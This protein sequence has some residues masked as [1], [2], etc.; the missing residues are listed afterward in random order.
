MLRGVSVL[1]AFTAGCFVDDPIAS[2]GETSHGIS[3]GSSSTSGDASGTTAAPVCGDGHVDDDEGCDDGNDV[4][5][6]GCDP[7]CAVEPPPLYA[8][9]TEAKVTGEVGPLATADALCQMEAAAAGLGGT[10][11]AWLSPNNTQAPVFRFAPHTRAYVLPGPDQPLL[12]VGIEGLI[13]T[14]HERG[15]NRYASGVELAA[16]GGCSAESLVWTGTSNDG[17]AEN[18][19]CEG[20]SSA[21][22][23]LKGRAGRFTANGAGWTTHCAIQCDSELPIYCFETPP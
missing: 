21:D 1:L 20:F 16:A 23:A 4:A 14:I 9:V 18:D 17:T 7:T 10:Y 19:T 6:D 8:F 13:G 2:S 3:E 22:P 5:G 15:L 12:A 11:M